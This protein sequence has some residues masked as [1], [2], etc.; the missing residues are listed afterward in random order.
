MIL[1]ELHN[2]KCNNNISH[3]DVHLF[4]SAMRPET[5]VIYEV[6]AVYSL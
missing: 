5:E 1:H 3:C 6:V 2:Y 4:P